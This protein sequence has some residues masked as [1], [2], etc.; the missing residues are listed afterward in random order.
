MLENTPDNR[1]QA[2]SLLQS[3]RLDPARAAYE[4]LTEAAPDD[5]DLVG[6]LAAVV[7]QK[8]DIR[9]AEA[10]F[11]RSLALGASP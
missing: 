3:G 5:A 10:L 7:L 9:A 1:K 6:L 2:L 4:A 8:G 11:R